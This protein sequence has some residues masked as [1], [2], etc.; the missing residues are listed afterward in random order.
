MRIVYCI[1]SVFNSGGMERI[2]AVK[3]N[4]LIEKGYDIYI[5]T[6]DQKDRKSF[7]EYLPQIK[8]VDLDINYSDN[9]GRH[10]PAWFIRRMSKGSLH[11]KRLRDLLLDIKPDI[12]ISMFQ[13]ESSFL[14]KLK[15]GSVKLIESH[16]CRYVRE[17]SFSSNFLSKIIAKYRVMADA[18][19]V[20]KYDRF[21]TL[22]N[23]DRLDWPKSDN[24]VVIPNPVVI[25]SKDVSSLDTKRIIAV[26]R[27]SYQKGF[28]RLIKAWNIVNHSRCD[29][30]L[31]IVGSDSNSR[32]TNELNDL[33]AY[34][35]L[36]NVTL[37]KPTIA[38]EQE[39]LNSSFLVMSSR[40]EGFGLVLIEAMSCGL[41]C[42]SFA[43]K[44]G[45]RDIITH[46][47]DG[48]LVEDGDI[49]QLANAMMELMEN[50]DK[51]KQM[52]INAENKAK[53]YGL[54]FI[55]EKWIELFQSCVNKKLEK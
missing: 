24:I 31:S 37:V 32:Y 30:S 42:V 2:L 33:I 15:D 40:Y 4:Y 11:K 23:E 18:R 8:F 54:S 7:F 47:K 27:I 10:T 55:M 49:L 22:T 13:H 46:G 26:G 9:K 12:T 36:D 20:C 38:I 39:Y 50:T 25:T 6:T 5:V 43:C 48:L 51:L 53:Q 16:F 34:Y 29:W 17:R 19:L 14:Y 3:A 52:G 41:P 28:D 1:P 45:P 21:I 44:C 35:G